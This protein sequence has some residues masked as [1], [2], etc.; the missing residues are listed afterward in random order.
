[1]IYKCTCLDCKHEFATRKSPANWGIVCCPMPV[2]RSPNIAF[3]EYDY[4][5]DFELVTV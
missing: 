5:R 2:C 4:H 3:S 1:M